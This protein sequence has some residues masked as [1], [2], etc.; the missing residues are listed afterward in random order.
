MK[1]LCIQQ[2]TSAP[3]HTSHDEGTAVRQQGVAAAEGQLRDVEGLVCVICASL[4]SGSHLMI[5]LQQES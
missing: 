1:R 3:C 5:N 2:L 4:P